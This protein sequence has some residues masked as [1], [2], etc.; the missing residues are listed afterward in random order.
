MATDKECP[1]A[2]VRRLAA[3]VTR[4]EVAAYWLAWEIARAREAALSPRSDPPRYALAA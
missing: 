3:K 2:G 4:L 1:G